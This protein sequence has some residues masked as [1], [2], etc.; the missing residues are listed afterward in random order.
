MITPNHWSQVVPATSFK[1]H[2]QLINLFI[3]KQHMK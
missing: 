1:H 3:F 2:K